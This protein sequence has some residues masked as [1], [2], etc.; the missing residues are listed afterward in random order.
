MP[1][2]LGAVTL[3]ALRRPVLASASL[4]L[5]IGAK[6]WPVMLL[7]LVLKP[8]LATSLFARP[9]LARPFFDRFGQLLA[10]LAILGLMAVAWALPPLLGGLGSDSGF[11]AYASHWQTNS[12]LFQGLQAAT[13]TLLSSLELAPDMA[14]M[15]VRLVTAGM[16]AAAAIWLTLQAS[17]EPAAIVRAAAFIVLAMLLLSPAQFPWYGAWVLVF[18][19]FILPA[20]MIG[21]TVFLPLYYVSFYFY[22]IGDFGYGVQWLVWIEWLP[23]WMLLGFDAWRQWRLPLRVDLSRA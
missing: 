8:L 7:P 5:A 18:A 12:A 16:V 14:G 2:V 13:K 22:G 20:G 6:L 11:V 1:F 23:I 19:P 3:L 9:P 17:D 21:L 15:I 4:G 10:A